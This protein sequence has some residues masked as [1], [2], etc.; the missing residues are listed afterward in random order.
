MR[1]LLD[2]NLSPK[3][4]ELLSGIFPESVHVRMVGL[5]SANDSEVWEF[6]KHNNLI[7]VSKESD[8]HQRSLVFGYPPKII[9]VRL[10]NCSTL[11][12]EKLLRRHLVSIKAFYEDK[13][14][15]FLSLS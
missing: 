11:E 8:M 12:V 5:E 10:G 6:A 2:Q 13:Y 3:L 14:A 4:A 9:W 7:I 1:L 15:S